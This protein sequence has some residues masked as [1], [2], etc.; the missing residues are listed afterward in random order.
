MIWDQV[1]IFHIPRILYHV[2]IKIILK[3]F[4]AINIDPGRPPVHEELLLIM[5]P[6][7]A[8]QLHCLIGVDAALYDRQLFLH[9]NVHLL[10]H[11]VQELFRQ[12]HVALQFSIDPVS[13][14]E[15]HLDLFDLFPGD[16]IIKGLQHYKNCASL[17]RLFPHRILKGQK[18]DLGLLRQRLVELLQLPVDPGQQDILLE[19]RLELLRHCKE[20]RPL[21]VFSG[22]SACMNLD[23]HKQTSYPT[24]LPPGNEPAFLKSVS[25]LP[26]FVSGIPP[27]SP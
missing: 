5:H 19:L 25:G 7:A 4:N 3:F 23:H 6:V 11:P 10:L 21:R 9:Q 14:G 12:G 24:P 15:I 16:H 18:F 22:L 17:I 2:S 1:K 27:Y 20:R 13:Q 8:E 26:A